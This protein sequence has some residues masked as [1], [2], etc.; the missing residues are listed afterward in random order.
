MPSALRELPYA[1]LPALSMFQIW[2][3]RI[4]PSRAWST[5][6]IG[7]HAFEADHVDADVVRVVD[8]VPFDEEVAH[9]AVD[10]QR[11]GRAQREVVELVVGDRDVLDGVRRVGAEDRDAV[12]VAAAASLEGRAHVVHVVAADRDAVRRA[13]DHDARGDMTRPVGGESGDVE[14]RDDHVVL[15]VD[16]DHGGQVGRHLQCRPV[17]D[18]G[19]AGCRRERDRRTRAPR[20]RDLDPLR[21]GTRL[22]EHRGACRHGIGG[23][24]QRGPRL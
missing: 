16:R 15:P 22:H 13:G 6:G 20:A 14:P 24:L 9:V 19:G 17:Q 7:R 2:L 21:V 3:L 10:H 5:V 8:A 1:G 11:L 23:V 18:H 12:G 4:T